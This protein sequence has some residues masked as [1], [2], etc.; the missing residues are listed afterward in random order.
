METI[1]NKVQ[2]SGLITLDLEKFHDPA[3]R[4]SLDISQFLVEGLVLIESRFR[5]SVKNLDT[6]T[7][8]DSIV[9]L[10][11]ST[12]AIVP[13]WAYMLIASQLQSIARSVYTC[14]PSQVEALVWS[15]IISNLDVKEYQ[16]KRII[17]AGCSN[18]PVPPL[19]YQ[20]LA[21]RLTPVVKSLFYG[22]ACS[23]VPIYK[24][25]K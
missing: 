20:Q 9:S 14:D 3:T 11:C 13:H 6:S 10:Y 16:D 1:R 7:Y 4:V 5:E 8:S 12:D 17:I 25:K 15:K 24:Q 23:S 2:E 22:E 21:S 19:A 18:V